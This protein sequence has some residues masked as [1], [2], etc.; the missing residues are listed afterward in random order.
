VG[1]EHGSFS[2]RLAEVF[3]GGVIF[4][5]CGGGVVLQGVFEILSVFCVVNRGE[6]VVG[7]W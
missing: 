2:V 4:L 1:S 3:E 7:L 5:W 6:V